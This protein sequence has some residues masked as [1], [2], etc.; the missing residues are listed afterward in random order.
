M[1]RPLTRLK[2]AAFLVDEICR[3]P[4]SPCRS[5]VMCPQCQLRQ[6]G[7]L[8]H[9]RCQ[10]TLRSVLPRI[11]CLRGWL[12]LAAA[13]LWTIVSSQRGLFHRLHLLLHRPLQW[14]LWNVRP[15]LDGLNITH[16]L[17]TDT[18]TN[19]QTHASRSTLGT[20]IATHICTMHRVGVRQ[21]GM[22]HNHGRIPN[23]RRYIILYS[24]H[25]HRMHC[26]KH[27]VCVKVRG[28][29]HT[30]S[31]PVVYRPTRQF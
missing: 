18:T 26:T 31:A 24:S 23:N 28:T 5:H 19:R 20:V 12:H 7:M 9:L 2:L 3:S 15:C 4:H 14:R 29:V 22:P 1:T 21:L 17:Q 16:H 27:K 13:R 25:T 10:D 6:H 30:V 11:A 8:R